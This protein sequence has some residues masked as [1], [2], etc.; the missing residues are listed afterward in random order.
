MPLG[1]RIAHMPREGR[2][3]IRDLFRE[4]LVSAADDLPKVKPE[5]TRVPPAFAGIGDVAED[6]GKLPNPSQRRSSA[7]A[8]ASSG[9]CF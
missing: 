2:L 7:S 3:G 1:Q 5:K 6:A 8:V 4:L 9:G